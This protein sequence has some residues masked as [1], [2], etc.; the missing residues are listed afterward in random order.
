MGV[1]I[2]YRCAA[3][4]CS[5][6]HNSATEG[7][8]VDVAALFTKPLAARKV[9]ACSAACR[10]RVQASVLKDLPFRGG[11]SGDAIISLS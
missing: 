10:R 9:W 6:V 4:G 8:W 5:A 1:P 2:P 3:E 11:K 7:T